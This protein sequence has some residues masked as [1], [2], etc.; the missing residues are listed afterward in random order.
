MQGKV[1]DK[2]LWN[3]P[4]SSEIDRSHS[5]MGDGHPLVPSP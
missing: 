1:T 3:R 4:P 5:P 2:T